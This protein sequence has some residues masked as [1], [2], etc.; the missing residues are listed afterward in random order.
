M[1]TQA[2]A[3]ISNTGGVCIQ[4]TFLMLKYF[5]G[6]TAFVTDNDL[7]LQMPGYENYPS[8]RQNEGICPPLY[9]HMLAYLYAEYV[10]FNYVEKYSLCF[11]LLLCKSVH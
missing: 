7:T 6:V 11:P 3:G 9:T 1:V 2:E 8:V 4:C 5:E 10:W